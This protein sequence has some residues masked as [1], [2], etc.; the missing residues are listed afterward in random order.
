M[1][2]EGPPAAPQGPLAETILGV[3][4]D[5]LPS[6]GSAQLGYFWKGIAADWP[7]TKDVPALDPQY[8]KFGDAE[9]WS[10]FSPS[11]R[12]QLLAQDQLP[13]RIQMRNRAG[14]RMIQVQNGRFHY[15]W[16][17][18]PGG[19]DYPLYETVRAEFDAA[20]EKFRE[21]LAREGLGE[22]KPNQ[23]E[24]TYINQILKGTLWDN[25]QDLAAV[26]RYP[27]VALPRLGLASLESTS[28]SWTGEIA[29]QHGRLHVAIQKGRMNTPAGPE[30][31]SLTL[32][33][34]GATVPDLDLGAGLDLGRRVVNAAFRQLVSDDALRYWGLD[35]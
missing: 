17:A 35:Q 1:V 27:G 5:P 32:T 7:T 11:V 34:R 31:V 19:G 4:F 28:A 3:Q 21:F 29:P 30:T 24:L 15:N 6:L 12:V 13:V 23:W 2:A 26:F 9:F 20:L 14:T 16:M 25:P 10:G 33:A 22:L 8:E 18:Q